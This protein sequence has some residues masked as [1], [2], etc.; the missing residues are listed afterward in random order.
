MREDGCLTDVEVKWLAVAIEDGRKARKEEDNF[1]HLQVCEECR[2]R[3][4]W[5]VHNRA[6]RQLRE[7]ERKYLGLKKPKGG[8]K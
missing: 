4:C 6:M 8:R 1:N 3:Y 2:R 7:Y 5:A